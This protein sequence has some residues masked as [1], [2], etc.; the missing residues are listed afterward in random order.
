MEFSLPTDFA[1]RM[2]ALLGD[3]YD[4]FQKAFTE[5]ENAVGI[6]VNT[7]KPN[8]TDRVSEKLGGFDPVPWCKNGTYGEKTV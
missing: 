5:S 2:K 6:R 4:K 1:E 3:E 7:L 8:A